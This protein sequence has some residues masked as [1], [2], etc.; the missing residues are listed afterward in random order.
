[1][2]GTEMTETCLECREDGIG[3]VYFIV[4]RSCFERNTDVEG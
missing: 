1:M 2:S 4:R 3:A